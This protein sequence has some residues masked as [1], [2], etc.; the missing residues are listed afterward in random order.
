M[1]IKFNSSLD[2]QIQ[3]IR[4]AID[5]F[6]GQPIKQS[7][8]EINVTTVNGLAFSDHGVSNQIVLNDGQLL[9]NV[10]RI[11][12][13]NDI[14]KTSTLKGREF[15]IEMETGTGKTYVY[16][17]TI[18]ELS[19]QYGLKKFIVVV[20][21]VAIRE[22]VLK[23][24]DMAKDHFRTLYDNEPFECFVY[25]SRKLGR[26][27]QFA[28][29]S[30][31]QIMVINI[32][33]FQKDVPNKD[34]A[35]MTEE[36]LKK[37]NII[38]R[39]NDKMSGYKPIEF[40]QKSRPLVII[41][42]PQSVSGANAKRAI[43]GL[44]PIATFRY[45]A[46]HRDPYNLIYQLDPV[47]A[48][49]LRLVKRIEVAS[50]SR[51]NGFNDAYVKLLKTDNK[52]GIKARLEIHKATHNAVK[53][54][55][56][57]VKQND[58]LFVK[59]GER[60]NYCEGYI[61]QN[62]DCTPGTECVEFGNGKSLN[63]LNAEIG[64]PNNAI[65]QAQ[66]YATVKQHLKKE[67]AFR[68]MAI[69]VLSLFFIDKVANYRIYNAGGPPSLGI[70]GKLFEQSY[71]ELTDR[72]KYKD[73][74]PEALGHE[75]SEIH[76]GYFS[77]DR[78]GHWRDSSERGSKTDDNTYSLIM[79]DKERLLDPK[80]PL[81]F[82]FSH[83]AL[84]EGW[85]NPNI[86][87]ICTLNESVSVQKK[88][89]EIGR[90]M[91]LPV[92][93]NGERVHDDEVNR[94]TVIANESYE[95]FAKSLQS[96]FEKDLGIKFGRVKKISFAKIT[97]NQNGNEVPIGQEESE[98]IWCNLLCGGYINEEGEIME[99]FDPR[100]PH[101][102]LKIGIKH[103]DVKAA[104]VDM[105]R[106][107]IFKNRVVNV[108]ERKSLNLKKKVLLDPE[109]V[110]LWDKIKHRTRYSVNF[111]TGKLVQRAVEYIKKLD[112]IQYIKIVTKRHA[113]DY[114]D[115][116]VSADRELEVDGRKAD[117]VE[118]L[119]DLLSYLQKETEL[120]RLTL[121]N[122]LKKSRRLPEFMINPQQFMTMVAREISRALN[123][124]MLKGIQYERIAG[125]CWEM[126]LIEK[127]ANPGI[128]RCLNNLYEVKNQSKYL[129]DFVEFDSEIEKQF[130][131][132]LD[133]NED[134]RLFVKLP[135]WFKIDTPVGSYNPDWAFVTGGAKKLYFVRETKSTTDRGELRVREEQK[136]YCGSRHFKAIGVDYDVVTKLSDV[137]L[138]G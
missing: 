46:T 28:T 32:Q 21:S 41:D 29:S 112:K 72:E 54:T 7:N 87:Q 133:Y 124:V 50:V 65:M 73:Y 130:A 76:N 63:K 26:V 77:K 91:R 66:I 61:V 109:F 33:S 78:R 121:F 6:E 119:P 53:S 64:A 97:R 79:R 74:A 122:I 4:A 1:K 131:K 47:R 84:R 113:I 100:N 59:S 11:Q 95:D 38:N 8:F 128:E 40:I 17:R 99:K 82:I 43:V 52:N 58:D 34:T 106:S 125:H 93:S 129:Y 14:E 48:Y 75:L 15:S 89:Q 42:E 9:E 49:D 123:D 56:L 138:K 105:M 39:E 90:G 85:D 101:F 67:L 24:I 70:I 136:T 117:S 57:W 19:K 115:A 104:I 22:G 127:V 83:S 126:S 18:F 23:H 92:N 137:N 55:K 114:S 12:E 5:V 37:L 135:R 86:F 80:E 107:F 132:D 102:E 103:E 81:R 25:D 108:Q 98:A 45:S 27:R 94:L 68:G 116:G 10:Q 2:Y 69:K 44:N 3:A 30:Q 134:V 51:D 110:A 120:T 60:E 35:K 36:E 111:D 118:A 62:I 16:L 20:P 88:R 96:E 31:I 71:K 13:E